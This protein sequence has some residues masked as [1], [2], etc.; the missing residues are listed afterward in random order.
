MTKMKKLA[1]LMIAVIFMAAFVLSSCSGSGSGNAIPFSE[2]ISG[3]EVCIWYEC[4]NKLEEDNDPYDLGILDPEEEEE[5]ET[6]AAE[7]GRET[8]VVWIRVYKNGKL[9]T[10]STAKNVYLGY[11][12]KMTD[13]EIVKALDTDKDTFICAQ[14]DQPFDIYLYSDS[15]GHEI[16]FEGVPT[17]I[18]LS[19]ANDPMYFMTLIS[20]ET[21]PAFQ[22]YDSYFGGFTLYNYDEKP[23]G[24]ACL[25]TRC[26]S[27]TVYCLDPLDLEG[28][29][30]DYATPED[31]LVEKNDELK[32]KQH[33]EGE[34][35]EEGETPE[36][37]TGE[38]AD[39]ADGTG[40]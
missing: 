34:E 20:S 15:T 5:E 39:A 38:N 26:E 8:R 37:E 3:E 28:A 7:F 29:I 32:A 21:V 25:V 17:L 2:T 13:E 24:E 9:S 6:T 19:D 10:Y 36:G 1:S 40:F 31:M 30:L 12:A 35:T 14:K 33:P 22:V 11:F 4:Q 23:F 18:K 16:K 27:G